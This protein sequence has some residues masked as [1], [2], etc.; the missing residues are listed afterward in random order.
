ME[1]PKNRFC[2]YLFGNMVHL[3]VIYIWEYHDLFSATP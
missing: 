1:I 3:F 2:M